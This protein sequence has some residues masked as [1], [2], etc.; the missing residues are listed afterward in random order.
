LH[1]PPQAALPFKTKPKVETKRKRKTLEQKRAVVL[2]AGERSK[3]TLISQLNAI[4]NQKAATRREARARQ[5]VAYDK[6]VAAQEVW[7]AQY[8]K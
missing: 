2:E 5:K 4:R 8:N 7:R 1:P 3:V 6:R